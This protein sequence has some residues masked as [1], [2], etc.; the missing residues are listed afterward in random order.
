MKVRNY[1]L[2]NDGVLR[3]HCETDK[4]LVDLLTH[5]NAGDLWNMV[6][7]RMGV[8]CNDDSY[9]ISGGFLCYPKVI[10]RKPIYSLQHDLLQLELSEFSKW[11]TYKRQ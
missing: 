8:V 7:E 3:L 10:P 11:E 4:E 1:E 6:N 5:I 9:T 2:K